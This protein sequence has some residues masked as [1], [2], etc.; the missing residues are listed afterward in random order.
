MRR[1]VWLLLGGWLLLAGTV[2][3]E[4]LV[5]ITDVVKRAFKATPGG[6]LELEMDRGNVE[7]FTTAESA[8][9]VEVIRTLQTERREEAERLLEGHQLTFEQEGES[10]YIKSQLSEDG[11]WRFWKRKNIRIR[12]EIRIRVPRRFSVAFTTGAGN[13]DIRDLEGTVEGET[14]AGNVT[15]RNLRGTVQISTGA[16]NVEVTELEGH[17]EAETGAGNITVKGLRGSADVETGAGNITAEFVAPP[18]KDSR[19]KSGAGNV[20]VFVP[21]RAGFMLDASTGIGSVSSDFEV[22]IDRDWISA[23]AR[24]KVNGGGPTLRLE[25]GL[26]NVSL[27]RL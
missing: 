6:H 13:V 14:G 20:T 15:L 18:E 8:V 9:Y 1:S 5:E 24:G 2:R 12:V 7:I 16:G 3:A 27:R 21:A 10:I 4:G 26:G 23:K 17:L 25:A 11:S 22:R 19:F